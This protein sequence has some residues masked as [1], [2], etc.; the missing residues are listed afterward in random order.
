MSELKKVIVVSAE[1][2]KKNGAS[3]TYQVALEDYSA[4]YEGKLFLKNYDKATEEWNEFDPENERD[5]KSLARIEKAKE[6]LGGDLLNCEDTELEMYV[7][8]KE[9]RAY[10]EKS[11]YIK[12]E[13]P[14]VSLKKVK[15][16]KIVQIRDSARG[17]SVIVE[18]KGHHYAFNFNASTWIDK[19][20]IFVPNKALLE[21]AKSRFDKL[22]ED[23][24]VTW[25]TADKAIGLIVNATVK[26][27]GF[28]KKSPEG[29]LEPD[30]ID[31]DDQV[32][33]DTQETEVELPF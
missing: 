30:P 5:E 19:K 32:D 18:H 16:A 31:P 20:K 22:F 14:L 7:D 26:E 8:D 4:I 29:W 10:F 11:N 21:K 27:N 17:R 24:N 25:D 1:K 2:D 9:G 23:V 6:L 13:K 15:G 28:D 33:V 12:V 3:I